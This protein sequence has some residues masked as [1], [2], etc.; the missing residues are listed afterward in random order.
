MYDGVRFCEHFLGLAR[1][2]HTSPCRR[3]LFLPWSYFLM[4]WCGVRSINVARLV[5]KKNAHTYRIKVA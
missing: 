4:P 2:G 1:T 5:Q 3:M